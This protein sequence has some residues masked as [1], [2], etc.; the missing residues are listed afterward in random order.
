[1]SDQLT[2]AAAAR[3]DAVQRVDDHADVDWKDQALDAVRRTCEQR[4]EFISDD[5]WEVG[6]LPSTRE[7]RALGAVMRKAARNGWC[8]KTDRVRPSV[9]SHLSGKPVWSS[10]LYAQEQA[11]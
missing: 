9:R 4:A 8:I 2:L 1:M 5:I 11:A 3:D 7:D 6:N 10:L